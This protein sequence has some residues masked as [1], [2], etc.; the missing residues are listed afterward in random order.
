M[1]WLLLVDYGRSPGGTATAIW[2]K[3]ISQASPQALFRGIQFTEELQRQIFN[4]FGNTTSSSPESNG[5]P[6]FWVCWFFPPHYLH[7]ITASYIKS[8]N[9]T[10]TKFELIFI[11][12][13]LRNHFYSRPLM[14]FLVQLQGWDYT[15]FQVTWAGYQYFLGNRFSFLYFFVRRK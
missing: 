7:V 5:W 9:R 4:L 15:H 12:K 11:L 10:S 6:Y 13:A 3:S 8:G 2:T 1:E 14:T